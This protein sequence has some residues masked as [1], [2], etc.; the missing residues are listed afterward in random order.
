VFLIILVI[1]AYI[2][3]GI[4]AFGISEARKAV[5]TDIVLIFCIVTV[6]NAA[7]SIYLFRKAESSKIEWALF[8]A[9]GN[10]NAI[11]FHWLFGASKKRT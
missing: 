7:S 11:L 10:V 3:A 6:C 1:S 8:G 4:A 9:I 2:G 5:P